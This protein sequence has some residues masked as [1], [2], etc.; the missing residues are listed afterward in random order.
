LLD[1]ETAMVSFLSY[2]ARLSRDEVNALVA[3]LLSDAPAVPASDGDV[4]TVQMV[5]HV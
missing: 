2:A 5:A 3:P 4:M 1:D